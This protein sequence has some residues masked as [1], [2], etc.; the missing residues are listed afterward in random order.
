MENNMSTL[1]KLTVPTHFLKVP[2]T[3]KK[4]KFRPFLSKE[5]KILMLVK[6]SENQDEMLNAMKDIIYACTFG[7]IDINSLS[8]FDIEFIFLNLRAKSV[9]EVIEIDMKCNNNISEEG[10]EEKICGGLIPFQIN[11]NEI[12][13]TFP[14]DHTCNVPL[15]D[16]IGITLRYP[17]IPDIKIMEDYGND[18]VSIIRHLLDSVY[19]ADNVYPIKDISPEEVDKF[20]DRMSSK[21]IEDVR[22]KFF[23]N[24]PTLEYKAKYKCPKCG[25]K[26][27]YTF[28]G[29][30]DFF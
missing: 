7:K 16:D 24:M 28:S 8:M 5:E 11:I 10:E 22:M 17:S 30:T 14:K 4:I 27:T 18:D 21:Q 19:D 20:M 13:V 9:G 6:Q 3:K 2:S 1:P 29:I 12:K 25:N 23:Y 15:Q 26:D